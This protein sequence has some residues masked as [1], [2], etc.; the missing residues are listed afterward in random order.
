M[1]HINDNNK[2]KVKIIIYYL[3]VIFYAIIF[4][5]IITTNFSKK[6]IN[7]LIVQFNMKQIYIS[8]LLQ[9]VKYEVKSFYYNKNKEVGI[10]IFKLLIPNFSLILLY[11][12]IIMTTNISIFH[13]LT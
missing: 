4:R 9:C 6:Y 3:L 1:K 8:A 7:I 10:I 5:K 12:Y 11:Q 2:A 13:I